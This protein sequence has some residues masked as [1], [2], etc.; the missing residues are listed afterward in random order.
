MSG[1]LR[2]IC[3]AFSFIST[4]AIG[5]VVELRFGGQ[6]EGNVERKD[7]ERA[8]Y[9]MVDV[10]SNVK[11]AIPE[12]QVARVS[13]RER[14]DEYRSQADT[15]E[16]GGDAEPHYELSI[17]CKKSG[18]LA[19]QKFHLQ[20]AI[21][22]N[23]EH[24]KARG[25]LGYVEAGGKWLRQAE[26]QKQRGMIWA[27]GRFR[28]PEEVAIADAR[29]DSTLDVKKWT[30]EIAR[31]RSAVLRGGDKGNDARQ[32]LAAIND[33][34]AAY[35]MASELND[36]Q[37]QPRSLR[38]FWLEKL[39][40]FGNR[41]ATEAL[42]RAGIDD[43]DSVIQEK[44]LEV[45]VAIA[46]STAI[47]NYLPMLKSNDNKRVRRAANVL[48]YF[49]DPEIALSLVDA[50]V[51]THK[52]EIAANQSTNVGFGADG[53]GGMST[54]GK[55]KVLVMK[56]DNPPVLATLRALVPDVDFG[57]DQTRWRQYFSSQLSNH[58]GQMRR[59][60]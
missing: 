34:A 40:E 56:V 19:Q 26:L 39:A 32:Q 15:I 22:I 47:A 60:P 49:P 5:D 9:V 17:W 25:A 52:Q 24:F 37:Q 18:L 14:L 30:R 29:A 43:P 7:T 46:P 58:A 10:A 2:I 36:N 54:G 1:R 33:P 42:V 28:L 38:V 55:A 51:T 12:A 27:D 11:I 13:D 16:A 31:L 4:I 50:L 3:V 48:A 6:V 35:A 41:S 53:S 8:P 20:R 21:A 59:D 57:Y 45:L 23:P 44:A